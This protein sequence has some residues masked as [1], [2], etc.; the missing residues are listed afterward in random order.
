[1]PLVPVLAGTASQIDYSEES[2]IIVSKTSTKSPRH[3][4]AKRIGSQFR[5]LAG[6][7]WEDCIATS[8]R[9]TQSM[10]SFSKQLLWIQASK[11]RQPSS[12][13]SLACLSAPGPPETQFQCNSL[14]R[15]LWESDEAGV[16]AW[17]VRISPRSQETKSIESCD[18]MLLALYHPQVLRPNSS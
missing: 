18:L 9:K 13:L 11:F 4:Q 6:T 16:P 12:R 14:Q 1:M 3:L 2:P 15:L 10:L 5:A 7:E 17:R 8:R